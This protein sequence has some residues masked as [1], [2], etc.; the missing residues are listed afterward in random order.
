MGDT[1][2]DLARSMSPQSIICPPPFYGLSGRHSHGRLRVHTQHKL[3]SFAV[4]HFLDKVEVWK[5]PHTDKK[6][7]VALSKFKH[8]SIVYAATQ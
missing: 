5:T 4:K 3:V 2:T 6:G 7:D 1:L 8:R